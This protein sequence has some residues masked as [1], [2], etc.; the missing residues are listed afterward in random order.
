M[1]DQLPSVCIGLEANKCL[2]PTIRHKDIMPIPRL[3][4]TGAIRQQHPENSVP[5]CIEVRGT[6]GAGMANTAV[7]QVWS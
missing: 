2:S 6:A 3:R 4:V 5:A 7:L 1:N